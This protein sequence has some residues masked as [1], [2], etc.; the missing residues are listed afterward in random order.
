MKGIL[1]AGGVGS[2]LRPITTV[3][4][5]QLLPIYDKPMIYYPLSVLMLAGIRE[6]LVITS[7][8]DAESYKKL[9]GDGRQFGVELSY[10][11]QKKPDGVASALILSEAFVGDDCCCLILG[12]NFFFGQAFTPLLENA[13]NH[14]GQAGGAYI[15]GY[16]VRDPERFGVV[17]FDTDLNVLSIQE[18]PKVPKSKYAITGLYF[19]DNQASGF[20]KQLSESSRGELEISDLNKMYLEKS[21]LKVEIFGRGFAWLDTG[22]YD[23][24]MDAGHFVQTIEKRQGYKIACLEEIAF[25]K[26]WL[27]ADEITARAE[28]MSDES[29]SKYLLE[30]IT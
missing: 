3:V 17:E 13:A 19:Y 20:A 16:P 10:Q 24:L 28:Q 2:R 22:T 1:L 7:A 4:S 30:L 15:F 8:E 29:Y 5:K 18:K 9:L 25:K 27:S 23:S 21:I 6:N 12:D 26:N 11:V 14:V